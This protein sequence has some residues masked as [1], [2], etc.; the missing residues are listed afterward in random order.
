MPKPLA[1]YPPRRA[2]EKRIFFFVPSGSFLMFLAEIK[3]ENFKKSEKKKSPGSTKM[4]KNDP[5][6]RYLNSKKTLFSKFQKRRPGIC[7]RGP[8]GSKLDPFSSI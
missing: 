6:N 7:T 5:S 1:P 2:I 4:T 8:R 3:N